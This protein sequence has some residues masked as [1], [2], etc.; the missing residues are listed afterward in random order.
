VNEKPK[1]W[2]TPE[3]LA[4][5][6]S[7]PTTEKFFAVLHKWRADLHAQWEVGTFSSDNPTVTAIATGNALAQVRLLKELSEIDA[8]RINEVMSDDD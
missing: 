7:D 6:K 1:L 4:G 5:W 8:E 3:E 2:M